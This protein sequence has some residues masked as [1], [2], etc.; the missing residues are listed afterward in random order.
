[1]T[2]GQKTETLSISIW[3]FFSEIAMQMQ[4]VDRNLT[5]ITKFRLKGTLR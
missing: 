1:M 2:S 5:A 4:L 3:E